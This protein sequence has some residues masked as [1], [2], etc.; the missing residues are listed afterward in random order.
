MEQLFLR[1]ETS[2]ANIPLERI[3]SLEVKDYYLVCHTVCGKDFCCSKPLNE[4]EGELPPYFIR[5]NRNTI[6]NLQKVRL[7]DFK[8]RTIFMNEKLAYQLAVRRMK[9]I[10]KAINEYE[11]FRRDIGE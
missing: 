2:A 10:R 8:E 11:A 7:V 4:I 1:N 6:V 5:I 3:L 9:A